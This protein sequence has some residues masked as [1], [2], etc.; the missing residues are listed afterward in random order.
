M[1]ISIPSNPRISA[2]PKA[3]ENLKRASFDLKKLI[4]KDIL[5]K[6][7]ISQFLFLI[8]IVSY[9]GKEFNINFSY[10]KFYI[11]NIIKTD[12]NKLLYIEIVLHQIFVKNYETE[13]NY[14]EFYYYISTLHKIKNKKTISSLKS[15]LFYVSSPVL[16]AHTDS[17]FYM[18][19]NR[20]NL[21]IEIAIASRGRNLEF[22]KKCL[23]VD[24]KF[25]DVSKNTTLETINNLGDVSYNFDVTIWQSV[26]VHLA[27]FRTLNQNVCLWTF[28]FHPNIPG[29]LNYIGSFYENKDKVYINNNLWKNLDIGFE[30][31]NQNQNIKI[32]EQRKLKFGSFCRE[33]LINNRLYWETVKIILNANKGA[34]YFYCGRKPIHNQWCAEL[35]IPNDEVV[36]LGWVNDPHKKLR[37]MAFLLDGFSL[38]HGYMALEAM[39]AS[40][41]IIFPASR[42][43]YGTSE[44]YLIKTMKFFDIKKE[45]DYKKNFLLNF[46]NENELVVLSKKLLTDKKFNDFYGQHYSKVVSKIQS[47]NFETFIKVICN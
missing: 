22:E 43:S 41:P 18:L 9:E 10:I 2:I 15:I 25:I 33:E 44:F 32:W 12:L 34:Q 1:N 42:T 20:E 28:K 6:S 17:L 45:S 40:V 38:G 16:L 8:G 11:S 46:K 29:L 23:E 37:D 39:A 7:N 14:N 19:K 13:K 21:S 5:L 35:D 36:F 3:V 4:T 24:V 27:Y 47:D 26:P 30:I 31:K